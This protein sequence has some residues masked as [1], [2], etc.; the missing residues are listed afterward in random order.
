MMQK[1]LHNFIIEEHVKNSLKEDIGF[2]DITTDFLYNESDDL[3]AQLNTREDTVVCGID[4]FKLVFSILSDEV[5]VKTFCND[6]DYVKAGTKLAELKG[7]ARAILIGERTAL[8]YMQRMSG[9]ATQTRKYQEAIAPYQAFV[10]DTR[11]NTPGF[12][13]FEKYSVMVG[14]AK[15]HRFNLSDCV[16]IKDNHIKHAGSI[17]AAVNLVKKNLSH[18]HKIEVEC[19]TF[20]QVKEA[21]S[22]GCDII[23]LD[24]MT[25]PDMKKCVE[26]I[27][28][29]VI[30]EASGNVKINTINEIASTGVDVISTSAIVAQAPVIDLGLDI[31]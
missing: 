20:D 29:K 3:T 26:F 23:M 10:T 18:A 5:E 12:R 14:G 11:K 4:V 13:M 19:D 16:M 6:G 25:I 7:P 15:L 21:L 30:V 28:N 22:S 9:I 24:N 8:N 1:L 17:T 2:G 31:F 27:G